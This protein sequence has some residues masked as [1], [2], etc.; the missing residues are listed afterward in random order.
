MKYT[1]NIFTF[2]MSRVS[3]VLFVINKTN[4]CTLR[5]FR[6]S[7]IIFPE[8]AKKSDRV[9]INGVEALFIYHWIHE[10]VNENTYNN[11]Y[12]NLNKCGCASLGM[13]ANTGLYRNMNTSQRA[14]QSVG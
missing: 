14:P 9:F 6:L 12:P 13:L 10:T 5:R 4:Q 7:Q 2:L 8:A 11:L 1:Y 3:E